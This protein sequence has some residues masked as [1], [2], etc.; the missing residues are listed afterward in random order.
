M[1]AWR[2][3]KNTEILDFRTR[4]DKRVSAKSTDFVLPSIQIFSTVKV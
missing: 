2:C 1:K 4:A 3:K